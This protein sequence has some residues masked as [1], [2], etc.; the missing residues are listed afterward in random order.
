MELS[1]KKRRLLNSS[2][3][4]LVNILGNTVGIWLAFLIILFFSGIIEDASWPGIQSFVHS[5]SLL[6]IS[7]S[8]FT[9][10]ITST[11]YLRQVNRYNLL[12]IIGLLTSSIIY[13]KFIGLGGEISVDKT[14]LNL[15]L[16]APLV[17]SV[18]LLFFTLK[19][20]KNIFIKSSWL[21]GANSS[22]NEYSIFL[23][24]AIAGNKTKHQRETIDKEISQ[25][26][27]K[28]TD[29]GY[30]N[31]F[32]ASNYF[33]T[34][35]DYQPPEVAAKEDFNAIENSKNFLLFYPTKVPS[36]ALVELGYALRDGKNITI[37]TK[38]K[39]FLPFLTRELGQIND[40]VHVVVY[41]DLQ[42]LLSILENSHQLYFV[43]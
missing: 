38:N 41:D 37:F 22:R 25:I 9:T 31:I 35:Q 36:S 12:A 14:Q 20:R 39:Q 29:L 26:E 33:S 27:S 15:P 8:L 28:L 3:I 13:A 34:E 40:L 30:R 23:S 2:L 43:K 18:I 7:F 21:N 10:V 4:L 1:I 19:D 24:F 11:M 32:N 17:L 6:I 42:N 5:G 16:F